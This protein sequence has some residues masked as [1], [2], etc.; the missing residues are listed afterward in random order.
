MWKKLHVTKNDRHFS[1]LLYLNS[2][3]HSTI[4][5]RFPPHCPLR[6]IISASLKLVTSCFHCEVW[7]KFCLVQDK[8]CKQEGGL[9][10]KSSHQSKNMLTN[11]NQ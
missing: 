7:K 4:L 10:S 11:Y 8:N 9:Q 1:L 2:M 5:P 6:S 3:Y